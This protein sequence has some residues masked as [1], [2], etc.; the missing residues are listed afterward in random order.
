M[1]LTK[2]QI[3]RHMR[4]I[5]MPEIGGKGQKKLL[6]T[7]VFTYGESV[8]QLSFLLYYLAASG[9]TRIYCCLK[10]IGGYENLF[11][12]IKDFNNDISI[13]LV[14]EQSLL[15]GGCG[16]DE[17]TEFSCSVILG[18]AE[19]VKNVK[20]HVMS[21]PVVVA[22]SSGWKCTLQTFDSIGGFESF[23]ENLK[24]ITSSKSCSNDGL[25]FKLGTAGAALS[26]ALCAVEAV[27][28]CLNIGEVQRNLLYM[29]ILSMEFETAEDGETG[30]FFDK[31]M[32]EDEPFLSHEDE[33]KLSDARVLI[34]GAGG[35]GS[36]AAFLLT[37]A[38]VG[39]IGLVD[40]DKVEISNLN[41]QILH[42]VSRLG[43]SKVDSAEAF[44]KDINP[45]INI[46]KHD[47]PL[48]EDNVMELVREYD[49][50]IS[51]VDNIP[52]RLLMNDAC[53]FLNKPLIESGVLRFNGMNTTLVPGEGHCY[54]CI[55]PE[56]SRVGLTCAETG[57]LGPVPG[58]MGFIEAAEAIKLIIGHENILK[59]KLLMYDALNSEFSIISIEKNPDCPLCGTDPTIHKVKQTDTECKT[60]GPNK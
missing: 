52:A 18:S 54:R 16:L 53:H 42:T 15:S 55:Y 21:Q 39:T 58:V 6:N 35:L 1:I 3:N 4:H 57:I 19:L 2:E 5:I 20:E 22:L 45:F 51:A 17:T 50:V 43:M 56:T 48:D 47:V 32:K 28:L 30:M 49:L 37:M 38:G 13:E 60:Y 10:D 33:K 59:N 34:V 24:G 12:S 11:D 7:K 26:G 27:K 41:R 14:D 9:I 36:P 8:E 31:L 25:Q 40:N 29:D 44:L 46:N 23:V